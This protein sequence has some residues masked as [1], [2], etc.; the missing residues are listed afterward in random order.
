MLEWHERYEVGVESID[1]AHKEIFRVINR[2]HKMIRVGGNTRWAAAEAVKYLKTYVLK[3]FHDE[4]EYMLSI[5]F[6]DYE[7][8]KSIHDGM[9]D[10]IVP[11]LYSQMESANYSDETITLFLTVCEKWLNRHIIG[12][13]RE[14]L[15]YLKSED[16][17]E[18]EKTR[19]A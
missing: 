11:R 4:E 12:H 17:E 8:H 14:L 2:L 16:E 1:N 3:H 15:K 18:G 9:R 10:R 7:T 13:D 5:G 6:R 19:E